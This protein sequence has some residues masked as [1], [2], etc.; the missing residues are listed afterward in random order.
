MGM[1]KQDD[2]WRLLHELWEQ[3]APLLPP[4]KPHPLG[5]HN[6]RVPDRAA[7]NAIIFALR[8]GCQWNAFNARGICSS[9]SAYRRFCEWLDTGIFEACWR[10][11]LLAADALEEI[12]WTW[13][14]LDVAKT[15]APLSGRE[16]IGSI[17]T[18][19]GKGG[20]KRSL[21][22]E[23]HAISL[24]VAIDRANRHDMKLVKPALADLKLHRPTDIGISARTLP[25]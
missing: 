24:A 21:L 25:G 6:P 1:V 19:R 10:L 8:T 18:D 20:V 15:K 16:K 12:D 7:M 5:C 13:L 11:G 22:T 23:A 17:P 4:R 2:G 14:S 9:T 3:M